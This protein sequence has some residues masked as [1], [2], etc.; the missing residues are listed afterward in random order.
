MLIWIQLVS[1]F[2]TA[3]NAELVGVGLCVVTG[4]ACHL[5]PTRTAPW[6]TVALAALIS[7]LAGS[8]LLQGGAGD[9]AV[10]GT[11][12]AG[13]AVVVLRANQNGRRWFAG[14]RHRVGWQR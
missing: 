14:A 11:A 7:S 9:Y 12:A 5:W 2:R 6:R 1:T 13:I 10:T 4:V 8:S 3:N